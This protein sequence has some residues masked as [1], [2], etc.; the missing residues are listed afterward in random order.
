MPLNRLT[1][2]DP[3]DDVPGWF[4]MAHP[5]KCIAEGPERGD[6]A[7]DKCPEC[8]SPVGITVWRED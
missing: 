8:G 2:T 4:C 7:P 3:N 6:K 1:G 5:L